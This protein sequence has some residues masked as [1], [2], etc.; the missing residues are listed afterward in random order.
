MDTVTKP[1]FVTLKEALEDAI[2]KEEY[3]A[4]ELLIST[5]AISKVYGVNPATAVRS[6]NMLREDGVI[7]KKRGI[8]MCVTQDARDIIIRRRRN[9]LFTKGIRDM[10]LEADKLG[11]TPMELSERLLSYSVVSQREGV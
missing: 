5:T 1:V 11:I 9:E 10:A 3:K 7:Y 8:G 2:I 6:V 4:G